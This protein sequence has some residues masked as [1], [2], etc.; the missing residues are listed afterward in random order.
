MKV[1][2]EGGRRS[3]IPWGEGGEPA[4]IR[5]QSELAASEVSIGAHHGEAVGPRA[6]ARPH[7][8]S[9][10]AMHLCS[11]K[12]LH[13]WHLHGRQS[14]KPLLQFRP[15]Q[16]QLHVSESVDLAYTGDDSAR[17]N[18]RFLHERGS[19]SCGLERTSQG[20]RRLSR[21][22]GCRRWRE[23]VPSMEGALQGALEPGPRPNTRGREIPCGVY[24]PKTNRG[25]QEQAVV[26]AHQAV[27]ASALQA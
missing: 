6:S 19:Q 13:G 5:Q 21:Q 1:N 4:G 9:R 14:P 22:Q 2:A 26:R 10:F 20:C 18:H 12:Y 16:L 17:L 24:S 11:Q 15:P 27:A 8:A 23:D 3:T 7:T 25:R